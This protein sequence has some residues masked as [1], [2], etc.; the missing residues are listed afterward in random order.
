MKTLERITTTLVYAS[1]VHPDLTSE[2]A[3]DADAIAWADAHPVAW[4]IVRGT[5]S[6]PFGKK[7]CTYLGCGRGDDPGSVI[8]RVGVLMSMVEGTPTSHA[9]DTFSFEKARFTLAHY[10]DKGFKGG[11][12]HQFDG[13]YDRGCTALD[14]TPETLEQVIDRFVA[15]CGP[16]FTTHHVRIDKAIVRRYPASEVR[17]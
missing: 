5:R 9:R 16:T 10:R 3:C 8:Y 15:W 7:S 13:T 14:Y 12:F 2:R 17:P 4:D 6:A 1:E 11:L